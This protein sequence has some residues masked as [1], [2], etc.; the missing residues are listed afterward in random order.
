MDLLLAA[1]KGETK[2]EN[3]QNDDRPKNI[4]EG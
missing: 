3:K 1:S 2:S 4:P